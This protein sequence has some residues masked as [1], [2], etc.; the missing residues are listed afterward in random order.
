M[1]IYK[2]PVFLFCMIL[3][4][5]CAQEQQEQ[6]EQQDQQEQQIQVLE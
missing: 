5:N 4:S 6:K 3:L 1:S 2:I